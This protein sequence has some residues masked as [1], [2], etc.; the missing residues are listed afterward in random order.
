MP[1]PNLM[2]LT[3]TRIFFKWDRHLACLKKITLFSFIFANL[4]KYQPDVT[5]CVCLPAACL[6][7][8]P[9]CRPLSAVLGTG[10]QRGSQAAKACSAQADLSAQTIKIQFSSSDPIA[11]DPIAD[12][13]A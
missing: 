7:V 2:F 3:F 5:A 10:R 13:I 4:N 11:A 6:C 1:P 12:P 9:A 8:A